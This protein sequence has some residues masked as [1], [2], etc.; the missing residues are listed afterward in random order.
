VFISTITET[1]E[2]TTPLKITN[3]IYDCGTSG[4]TIT[5]TGGTPN[6]Q[7]STNG[8]T[9]YESPT[10]LTTYTTS[11]TGTSFNVKVK[12]SYGA[13]DTWVEILCQGNLTVVPVY[14]DNLSE[15]YVTMSTGNT[16]YTE[17]FTVTDSLNQIVNFSATTLNNTTFVGWSYYNNDKTKPPFRIQNTHTRVILTNEIIYALFKNDTVY[18]LNFCFVST[19]LNYELTCEERGVFC[20]QCKN[21]IPIYFTK[22]D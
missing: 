18:K 4:V 8:G 15:G 1:L 13:I 19:T 7:Y 3:V 12:D 6:Y 5:I 10:S 11:F 21:V 20:A 17:S 2:G 16:Q 14:L 22:T 9:T